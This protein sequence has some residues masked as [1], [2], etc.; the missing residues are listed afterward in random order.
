MKSTAEIIASIARPRAAV[1]GRAQAVAEVANEMMRGDGMHAEI[2][3]TATD[4][5]FDVICNAAERRI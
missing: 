1:V 3:R 4:D 5:E 2:M